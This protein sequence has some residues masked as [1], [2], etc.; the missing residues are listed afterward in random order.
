[1]PNVLT[2]NIGLDLNA[3]RAR[4]KQ[5][6]SIVENIRTAIDKVFACRMPEEE[7]VS[8]NTNPTR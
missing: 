4:C 8:W 3:Y 1:M 6:E 2:L 5:D 7:I